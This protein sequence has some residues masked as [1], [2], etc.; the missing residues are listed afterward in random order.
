MSQFV[1]NSKFISARQY[2]QYVISRKRQEQPRV[3]LVNCVEPEVDVQQLQQEGS[4]KEDKEQSIICVSTGIDTSC[5]ITDESQQQVAK[6]LEQEQEIVVNPISK[7]L[8]TLL[9]I[10]PFFFWGTSMVS[11]KEVVPHTT[12]LFVACVRLIPSGILLVWWAAQSGRKW[13][14]GFMAWMSLILF[15]IVDGTGFQGFLAEGLQRTTAGLGS[16]VIDSQPISV[17]ILAALF[18]G[19]NI[20]AK[21]IAGLVL[22]V[23]GLLMIEVPPSVLATLDFR[24]E[25][26]SLWQSGEFLMLLAAQS[27]A[28]GTVMVPWV[29]RYND[30]VMATGWH[31][32]LGG[33]PLLAI[34]LSAESSELF[35]RLQLFTPSDMVALTYSSLFGGA[36]GYGVFFYNASK[37]NLTKLSSLTFLTPIFAVVTGYL[38]LEEGLTPLQLL[39]ATII[40]AG[41][42]MV[43]TQSNKQENQ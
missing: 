17:A 1:C 30:P 7:L 39:G 13:P 20:T 37:G 6:E 2:L 34:S 35:D 19:E 4:V 21:G 14:S 32:I 16:V 29:T 9:L 43:N 3:P 28:L 36:A 15:G 5:A 23:V 40:L 18:L 8:S 33:L 42:F 11:M 10:S 27:M 22:G 31:M 12:P 24:P 41:V 26:S 25:S 38:F